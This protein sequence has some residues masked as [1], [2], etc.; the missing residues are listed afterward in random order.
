MAERVSGKHALHWLRPLAVFWIVASC[1]SS[2]A[3]NDD[4]WLWVFSAPDSATMPNTVVEK[5]GPN[6]DT[7]FKAGQ[8]FVSSHY[9]A[10]TVIKAGTVTNECRLNCK[11][12]TGFQADDCQQV[13]PIP[14]P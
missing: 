7:C 13:I 14:L 5:T 3:T 8:D 6:L 4:E 11:Q 10:S 2:T 9:L 1:A 12:V